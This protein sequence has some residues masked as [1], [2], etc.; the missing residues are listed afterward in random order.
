MNLQNAKLKQSEIGQDEAKG[1]LKSEGICVEEKMTQPKRAGKVPRPVWSVTGRIKGIKHHLYD[2]GGKRW[3][4]GVSFF[5]EDPTLEIAEKIKEEGRLSFAEQQEQKEERDQRRLEKFNGYS[6]NAATRAE[7]RF[8]SSDDL[9]KHIPFG[10]PILIGHHSEKRHRRTLERSHNHIS[11]GLEEHDKS[12]Y[13]NRR[14]GSIHYRLE[15]QKYDLGYLQNR[16]NEN[17]AKLRKLEREKKWFSDY[18]CRKQE[19]EE[20]LSYFK[21]LRN[22]V[23]EEQREN[24]KIIPGPST[25]DKGDRVKYRGTWYEV[26]RVN[27]KS[28]T[29]KGWLGVDSMTWKP[30]YAEISDIKKGA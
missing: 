22:E 2:L 4:A 19:L 16:I 25:V 21:G 26:I 30:S 11:K 5:N 7:A 28:V 9:T 29:V 10:Q 24:G 13:Y 6:D 18:E 3:G 20:K 1:I 14:A 8:K 12:K 23:I 15:S 27:K 17:E